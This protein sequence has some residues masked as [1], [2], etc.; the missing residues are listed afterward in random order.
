MYVF[1]RLLGCVGQRRGF[2]VWFACKQLGIHGRQQQLRLM[3]IRAWHPPPQLS[4][5]HDDVNSKQ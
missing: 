3:K 4:L 1:F 5:T 2:E